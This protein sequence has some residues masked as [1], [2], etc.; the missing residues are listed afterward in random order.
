MLVVVEH[1]QEVTNIVQTFNL[2]LVPYKL[3]AS[4][5]HS[6]FKETIY[7]NGLDLFVVLGGYGASYELAIMDYVR[8]LNSIESESRNLTGRDKFA[9]GIDCYS[10]S[11]WYEKSNQVTPG[12]IVIPNQIVS[13][14]P[15]A[16]GCYEIYY[17][18]FISVSFLK[19]LLPNSHTGIA[20][21]W[22]HAVS[23]LSSNL[24]TDKQ[25]YSTWQQFALELSEKRQI[26]FA[27][28]SCYYL[29]RST[30]YAD[31]KFVSIGYIRETFTNEYKVRTP[32]QKEQNNKVIC[33]LI[34]N[35][36]E[37]LE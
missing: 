36:Y 21:A 2:Q 10:P 4:M 5:Y 37:R 17:P 9:V 33:N 1:S 6:N 30:T 22:D 34:Q 24:T 25:W 18:D 31:M 23:N 3:K 12:D 32:E 26:A 11:M 8:L 29:A 15:L 19:T 28:Y 20:T 16:Y 35:L 13:W 14:K 7:W 27:D